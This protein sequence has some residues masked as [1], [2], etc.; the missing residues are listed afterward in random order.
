MR[1][2]FEELEIRRVFSSSRVEQFETDA[3]R[4][5]NT[6]SMPLVHE[7]GTTHRRPPVGHP[8]WITADF[9]VTAPV[10]KLRGC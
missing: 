6:T 3:E 5:A 4:P 9:F 10:R 1:C 7:T 8:K 2:G